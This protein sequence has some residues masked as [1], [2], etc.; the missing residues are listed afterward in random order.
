MSLVPKL[1]I[2]NPNFENGLKKFHGHA[3]GD[4]SVVWKK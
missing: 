2:R 4:Q 1:R 3:I